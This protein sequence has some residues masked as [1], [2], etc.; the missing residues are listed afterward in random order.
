MGFPQINQKFIISH[1]PKQTPKK[2]KKNN[3]KIKIK[4]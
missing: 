4:I 1:I 2:N 3:K